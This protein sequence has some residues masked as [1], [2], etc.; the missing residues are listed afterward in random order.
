MHQNLPESL[1]RKRE[2]RLTVAQAAA[3]LGVAP[4]TLNCWRS[5]RRHD[6]PHVQ[7]GARVFYRAEDLDKFIETRTVAV[8]K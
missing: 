1:A 2:S 4:H 5:S 8:A 3:Y 6:I 7:V